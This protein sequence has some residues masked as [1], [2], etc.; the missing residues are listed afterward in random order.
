MNTTA[1]IFAAALAAGIVQ[2][3][4]GFGAGI[5]MMMFLPLAFAMPVAAGI[6]SAVAICLGSLMAWTYRDSINVRKIIPV[7]ALFLLISSI[8]IRYSVYVP[9]AVIKK[10][11][12]IFLI[13]LSIYYLF[14]N[15]NSEKKPMSLAAAVIAI[16]VSAL[17]DAFFAIGGPLMV[18]YYLAK[19]DT[20]REYLGTIQMFFLVNNLWNTSVRLFN[21]I[22]GM[23]QIPVVLA[24]MAGIALGGVIGGKLVTKIS[25]DR[26]K[27]LTYIMIGVSGVINVL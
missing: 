13:I 25:A 20:S 2:G 24:G 1:M 9:Q 16:A 23:E 27:K 22:I 12:G 4:T 8:A 10:V 18:L 21:G 17:C 15:R 14:I 5:I 11:F 7:S 19:T 6:S 26:L 3:I